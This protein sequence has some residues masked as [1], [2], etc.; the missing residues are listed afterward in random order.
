MDSL[1]KV[2]LLFR[3][4]FLLRRPQQLWGTGECFQTAPKNKLY[5][6]LKIFWS[7]RHVIFFI[8]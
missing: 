8:P 2:K 1:S 6:P 4:A 7:L 5:I 3:A